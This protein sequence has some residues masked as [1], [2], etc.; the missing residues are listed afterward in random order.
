MLTVKKTAPNRIDIEL[1]GG[2][3][4]EM[5]RTALEVLI[6]ESEDVQGGKMLYVVKEFAVPQ[7][8]AIFVELQFLPKLFG[9]LGKFDRCAFVSDDSWLRTAAEIE[10]A[11]FPGIEI[12]SFQP[13]AM[14][15]A[16]AWLASLVCSSCGKNNQ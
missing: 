1:D 3:D 10:G 8:G 16:E 2:L 15:E 6:S 4:D 14:A 11:I 5:M 13:T 7:L 9:L 12:K